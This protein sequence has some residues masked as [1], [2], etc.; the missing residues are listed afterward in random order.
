[1]RKLLVFFVLIMFSS[2]CYPGST[3]IPISSKSKK[4]FISAGNTSTI[5]SYLELFK[6]GKLTGR[7]I[8]ITPVKSSN[9]YVS[10][11]TPYELNI[12][13]YS[14]NLVNFRFEFIDIKDNVSAF[15]N[16]LFLQKIIFIL[17]KTGFRPRITDAFRTQENQ[18]KYKRR[19]W[20]NVEISPHLLGL[21]ADMVDYS[22][23]D[24]EIIKK[25]AEKLGLKFLFHGGR[26]NRH[27]H[28]QDEK[29]WQRFK[30][31]DVPEICDTLNILLREHIDL[32]DVEEA[33]SLD[34]HTGSIFSYHF[35][36]ENYDR[37][38]FRI[39]NIYGEKVAE[40]NTGIFEPGEYNV[41]TRF[42]FLKKGFY[43]VNIYEG[44]RFVRQEY[45]VSY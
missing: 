12:K 35:N 6:D 18:L 9:Y 8:I 13:N 27:I 17:S 14:L 45:Y 32:K 16:K 31:M 38:I 37:L 5:I 26:G 21:A 20:S 24:R 41:N 19:R 30:D 39:E 4:N 28:L 40:I 3:G 43:K 29:L 22:A 33:D 25:L 10:N 7:N 23:P 1:M 11:T 42:D 2:A 36:T 44:Y 34:T 15:L